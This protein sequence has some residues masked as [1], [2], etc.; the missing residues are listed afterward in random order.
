MHVAFKTCHV[1]DFI[2]TLC[3]K[4][5]QVRR[6]HWNENVGNSG[7]GKAQHKIH[8]RL[9]LGGGQAYESSED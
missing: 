9:K 3:R 2:K 5:A 8:K 6:N 7:Q 4:N 1:Y